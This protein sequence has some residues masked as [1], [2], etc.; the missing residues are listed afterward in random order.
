MDKTS[1]M[2]RKKKTAE[3]QKNDKKG[4][5]KRLENYKLNSDLVQQASKRLQDIVLSMLDDAVKPQRFIKQVHYLN[6]DGYEDIIEERSI[7]SL[8]G[9]PMCGN[10]FTD[11]YGIRT[12]IIRSN[13]VYDVTQRRKFCS[14]LCFALSKYV[15]NQIDSSPLY[16][17]DEEETE[18][19]YVHLPNSESIK[20]R[21]GDLIDVTGGLLDLEDDDLLVT[22]QMAE[23]RKVKKSKV[24][25]S[26]VKKSKDS[27]KSFSCISDVAI[28][29]LIQ[30]S[31]NKTRQEENSPDGSKEKTKSCEDSNEF[32][33]SMKN[34]SDRKSKKVKT[35]KFDNI[36]NSATNKVQS[37]ESSEIENYDSKN[38]DEN[39]IDEVSESLNVMHINK[40]FII[41]EE[42][43]NTLARDVGRLDIIEPI[44][45][46]HC[47]T[48]SKTSSTSSNDTNERNKLGSVKV[49]IELP[50]DCQKPT[51]LEAVHQVEQYLREWMTFETL[52]TILGDKYVRGMLEHLGHSWEDYDSVQG[53]RLGME[54]KAKYISLCRKLDKEEQEEL[55]NDDIELPEENLSSSSSRPK[56]QLPDYQKLATDTK[57]KGLKVVAFLQGK[58]CFTDEK[59]EDIIMENDWPDANKLD[60]IAEETGTGNTTTATNKTEVETDNIKKK[61][62]LKRA[63]VKDSESVES[64]VRLPHVDSYSQNTWRRQIVMEKL[65]KTL[66]EFCDSL[67][68]LEGELRGLVTEIIATFDLSPHNIMLKPGQWTLVALALLQMLSVRYKVIESAMKTSNGHLL[69]KMIL[70]GYGLDRDYL[71]RLLTY[72]TQIN[73]ILTKYHKNSPQYA[74]AMKSDSCGECQKESME[75]TKESK[76]ILSEKV[77]DSVMHVDKEHLVNSQLSKEDTRIIYGTNAEELD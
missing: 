48:N 41:D 63:S 30:C 22:S 76:I 28:D 45:K 36:D 16:L 6:P 42:I 74:Q 61:V 60:K 71:Q 43:N 13:R 54:A 59:E 77:P 47:N 19:K 67:D 10:K 39:K 4:K 1:P 58:D 57:Q 75:N 29:S 24:K 21:I 46:I 55:Y 65:S 53:L 64:D 23:Q 38:K 68:L 37:K 2:K 49:D 7:T 34:T 12:Y 25:Q 9:Y 17:R 70:E 69:I 14:D 40:D 35:V 26:K 11:E 44:S 15:G 32:K 31:E 56:G 27:N 62:K 51:S 66:G 73:Y 72:I 18:I 52:R 20:P 33:R 50:E 3:A 5:N 8:C